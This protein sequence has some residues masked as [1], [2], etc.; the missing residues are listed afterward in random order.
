MSAE[1]KD[2][3]SVIVE[4]YKA[5]IDYAKHLT[6]LSTGSIVLLTVFAEKVFPAPVW[7]AAAAASI[8]GFMISILGG[9]IVHTV[10]VRAMAMRGQ[11][12]WAAEFAGQSMVWML[13]LG[14]LIGILSL[15]VFAIA[16]LL[17]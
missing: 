14:F 6:T 13:W 15:A 16:N 10:F 2:N 5:N 9:L 17:R 12:D 4:V 8:V 1:G 7:K 11:A 3:Q